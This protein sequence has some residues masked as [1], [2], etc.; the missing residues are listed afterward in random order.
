MEQFSALCQKHPR[1]AIIVDF[2][3][4]WCGPCQRIAPVFSQ[5]AQQYGQQAIFCK[6]DTD[7]SPALKNAA[8]VSGI[9]HFIF[10]R[11]GAKFDE[12]VGANAGSLLQKVMAAIA[13]TSGGSSSSGGASKSDSG[14][15]AADLSHYVIFQGSN[16][17]NTTARRRATVKASNFALDAVAHSD[18]KVLARS[19]TKAL[20]SA[21]ALGSSEIS[22]LQDLED[23]LERDN[24]WHA[25]ALPSRGV[26]VL[27]KMLDGWP[28]PFCIPALDLARLA[29]LHPDGMDAMAQSATQLPSNVACYA[30]GRVGFNPV[31]TRLALR[32]CANFVASAGRQGRRLPSALVKKLL[33]IC[34]KHTANT[35]DRPVR[36]AVS[37]LLFNVVCSVLNGLDGGAAGSGSDTS[38]S[39]AT[40]IAVLL[41]GMEGNAS[42]QRGGGGGG[43]VDSD[44]TTLL[45]IRRCLNVLAEIVARAPDAAGSASSSSSS[46]GGVDM[47]LAIGNAATTVRSSDDGIM[48]M[49]KKLLDAVARKKRT[50]DGAGASGGGA[51]GSFPNP[52]A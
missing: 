20:A 36:D 33:E 32:F 38:L 52:W 15:S 22:Q 9:P 18:G 19:E 8:G 21:A 50:E 39:A 5:M 26:A 23:V 41:L 24:M 16:T 49:R 40:G 1:A 31:N 17:K 2:G 11:G 44:K 29:V 13:A 37:A 10:Y 4:T 48:R 35:G 51:G 6:V 14:S 12:L 47:W 27:G 42:R 28:H 43:G 7:E 3:A 25:G 46:G 45:V 30:E 34:Q